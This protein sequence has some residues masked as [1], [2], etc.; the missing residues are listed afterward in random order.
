MNFSKEFPVLANCTYLNTANSGVLSQSVLNWRRAHDEKFMQA[1]SQ[2]R[3]HQVEFL[4]GIRQQLARFFK[5]NLD[6]TF[7]VPNFSFGFNTFLDGLAASHRFLLVRSDYP[8]VNYP[9]ESR[10]FSC[11]YVEQNEL[12]EEN[13]LEKVKTFKPTVLALSLVQY[14][15][16]IKIDFGFI[17]KLKADY[18]DLVIIADGTQ[19]CGTEDF[20]FEASGLDALISSGYKWMLGGY[21]NGF[22]MINDRVAEFLYQERRR[23]HLPKE[24]FLKG[25]TQ[26]SLCFEPGHLDTL[27]FGTLGQSMLYLENLGFEY[28]E[29]C[30]K[31]ISEAAKNAFTERGLL[32]GDVI[33]QAQL[34]SIFNIKSDE[35]LA[36]RLQKASIICVPR[37]KGLR[38]SFHFYNSEQDLQE[39]LNVIDHL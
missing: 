12:L 6:N 5:G 11:G 3:A 32:S 16:G 39:L 25:K 8:S 34:S 20:N 10:G 28:I 9:V 15:S 35:K 13:I 2:F 23:Y 27:N 36:R 4:Q 21:G 31:S 1:G 30:I 14:T 22:V 7:L 33:R 18:P 37:G 19:Y 38:V 26:L 29:N 17:K 24:P